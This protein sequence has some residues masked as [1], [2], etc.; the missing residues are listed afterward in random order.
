MKRRSKGGRHNSVSDIIVFCL[1]ASVFFLPF[2]IHFARKGIYRGRERQVLKDFAAEFPAAEVIET[3]YEGSAFAPD[4]VTVYAIDT[5]LGF[6][7]I[8]N[9]HRAGG[10]TRSKTELGCYELRLAARQAADRVAAQIP[11]YLTEGCSVRYAADGAAGFAV[12]TEETDRGTLTALWNGLRETAESGE[13]PVQF[14]V[15]IAEPDLLERM[16]SRTPSEIIRAQEVAF[17]SISGDSINLEVPTFWDGPCSSLFYDYV[18]DPEQ[19]FDHMDEA[20]SA[21]TIDRFV[22]QLRSD[23]D[24][25]EYIMTVFNVW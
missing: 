24:R 5:E 20:C 4:P 17:R 15:I 19:G 16:L 18:T 22:R 3:R 6:P 14:S 9:Y 7:F 25:T 10:Y 11:Q 8:S 1:L 12:F 13:M 2:I 21:N 23:P